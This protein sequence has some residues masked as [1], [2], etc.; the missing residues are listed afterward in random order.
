MASLK[1]NF[2]PWSE[3]VLKPHRTKLP[4]QSSG[5]QKILIQLNAI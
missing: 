1:E 2:F 3:H 4:V 5:E